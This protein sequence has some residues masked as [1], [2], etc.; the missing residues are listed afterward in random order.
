M[1]MYYFFNGIRQSD[2]SI[3]EH[4]RKSDLISGTDIVK[5]GKSLAQLAGSSR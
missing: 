3:I 2:V 5:G 1:A 4:A